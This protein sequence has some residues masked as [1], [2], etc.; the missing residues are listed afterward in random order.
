[1][2]DQDTPTHHRI[3]PA[4]EEFAVWIETVVEQARANHNSALK[5]IWQPRR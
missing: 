3:W 5:M 2:E 1:M 4:M